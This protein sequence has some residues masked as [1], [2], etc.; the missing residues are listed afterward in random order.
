[1][2]VNTCFENANKVFQIDFGFIDGVQSISI[3]VSQ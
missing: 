2:F 3:Q 1:M